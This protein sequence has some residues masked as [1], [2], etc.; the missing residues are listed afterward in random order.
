MRK[1]CMLLMLLFCCM[2]VLGAEPAARAEPYRDKNRFFELVPPAEWQKRE[3]NDP[4]SKVEFFVPAPVARQSK[5]SLFLLSIRP[6]NPCG[7]QA[8]REA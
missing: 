4:R 3:F 5:A 2:P 7:A 1:P 6:A 8:D